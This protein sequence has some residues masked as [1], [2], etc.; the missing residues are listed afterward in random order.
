MDR[1]G[2]RTPSTFGA[3]DCAAL[4]AH[5]EERHEAEKAEF[6]KKLKTLNGLFG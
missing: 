2:L 6:E 3:G 4:L 5:F 1:V